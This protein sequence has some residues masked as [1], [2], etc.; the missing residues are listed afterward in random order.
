MCLRGLGL[1]CGLGCS[2]SLSLSL[3]KELLELYWIC[4]ISTTKLVLDMYGV[5]CFES[6]LL[7]F[8]PKMS[9]PNAC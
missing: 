9:Y 1:F 3:S 7:G 2:L 6:V 4:T 8:Y 5:M